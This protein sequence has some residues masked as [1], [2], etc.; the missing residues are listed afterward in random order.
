MAKD[1]YRIY[2]P[3]EAWASEN[4]GYPEPMKYVTR[5]QPIPPVPDPTVYLEGPTTALST[6]PTPSAPEGAGKKTKK[7]KKKKTK[8]PSS[9]EGP[10]A[11]VEETPSRRLSA[12]TITA[13][14]LLSVLSLLLVGFATYLVGTKTGRTEGYR[15]GYA[16]ASKTVALSADNAAQQLQSVKA[17]SSSMSSSLTAMLPLVNPCSDTYGKREIS[18][19]TWGKYGW[20]CKFTDTKGHQF[21]VLIGESDRT[22]VGTPKVETRRNGQTKGCLATGSPSQNPAFG[23]TVWVADSGDVDSCSFARE[24]WE[25]AA[26]ESARS[27]DTHNNDTNEPS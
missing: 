20:G 18:Q 6:P 12:A 27:E 1:D 26:A 15:Q 14:V 19:T 3:S 10:S 17:Q 22:H 7:S 11:P 4:T 13:L 25:Q 9:S 2:T 24:K 21:S 5:E 8:G 16:D 23:L